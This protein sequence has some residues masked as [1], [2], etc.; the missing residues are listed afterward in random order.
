MGGRNRG[1]QGSFTQTDPLTL[2][3]GR[4]SSP[5][6]KIGILK[7]YPPR[8]PPTVSPQGSN[9]FTPEI[10][11]P[12]WRVNRPMA[13]TDEVLIRLDAVKWQIVKAGGHRF[14]IPLCPKHNLR[15][16]PTGGDYSDLSF[17]LECAECDQ[18]YEIP[19]RFGEE[20]KYVSQQSRF[21]TFQADENP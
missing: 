2:T 15:L 11:C 18:P 19:R 8:R 4:H 21:Q 16:T 7:N 6:P 17:S 1:T 9:S 12:R 5:R 14:P 13:N 10:S 3:T 20:K